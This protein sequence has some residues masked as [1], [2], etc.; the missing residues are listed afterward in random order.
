MFS[1]RAT[2]NMLLKIYRPKIIIYNISKLDRYYF[3]YH[4]KGMRKI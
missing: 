4:F 1:T 3:F 2:Q